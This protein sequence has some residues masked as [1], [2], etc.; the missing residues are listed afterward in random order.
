MLKN[1]SSTNYQIIF[2]HRLA[3]VCPFFDYE[4]YESYNFKPFSDIIQ[5]IFEKRAGILLNHKR[6]EGV[7]LEYMSYRKI[8][9]FIGCITPVY[10]DD[11]PVPPLEK[12][13]AEDSELQDIRFNLI[14]WVISEDLDAKDIKRIDQKYLP[15]ALTLRFLVKVYIDYF[16][17][18]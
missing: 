12:L 7:Q 17:L 14:S 5:P 11:I 8:D 3:I 4:N 10:P 18:D 13:W 1:S 15:D 2:G 16:S 9:C 6:S